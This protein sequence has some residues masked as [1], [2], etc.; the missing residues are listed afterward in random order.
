MLW[1]LNHVLKATVRGARDSRVPLITGLAGTKLD[2]RRPRRSTRLQP[3]PASP[4]SAARTFSS[5]PGGPRQGRMIT[6]MKYPVLARRAACMAVGIAALVAG[7][8]KAATTTSI[9]T[10]AC[11]NPLLTQPFLSAHDSNWYTLIPGQTPGNF[12]GTGWQL[13]GGARII[14]TK[15]ADGST[16]QPQEHRPGPRPAD[17]LDA[18][19]PGER[20]AQQHT[21]MAAGPVHVHRRWQHERLPALRHLHRPALQDVARPEYARSS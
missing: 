4:A 6:H 15:L 21:R 1:S 17:S 19:D 16:D 3:L 14:T 12:D 9:D 7:S 10:S 20:P 13:S 2:R 5:V 11:A 18:V 8:A